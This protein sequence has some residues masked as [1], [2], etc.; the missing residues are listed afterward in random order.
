MLGMAL[1][2]PACSSDSNTAPTN[3][4]G[5][6]TPAPVETA[7]PEPPTNVSIT[8]IIFLN[9]AGNFDPPNPDNEV[10]KE[11]EKRTNTKL[12]INWV[13]DNDYGAKLA[14]IL[15]G[16]DLSDLVF[17]NDIFSSQFQTMAAQGAFW[18]LSDLIN[19]ND[20]PHLTAFPEESW[21]NSKL[22]DGKNYV[23]PKV[24]P[25][26]GNGH[27]IIR[28]DWLDNLKLEVPATLDELY[29]AAKAFTE[30][31][32]DGNKQKDT[33]GFGGES[34]QYI[35][36]AFT[37][38]QGDW[39]LRDGKLINV[40]LLPEM[41]EA[42]LYLNKAY[43]EGLIPV[44]FSVMGKTKANQLGQ[45]GQA[46]IFW[47]VAYWNWALLEPLLKMNPQ[48]SFIA[49]PT[50][51]GYTPQ[52]S[53]F[54]GG[55]AIPRTVPE[56]K[57]KKLLK[58]MDYGA[59]EEGVEL[60]WYG[61]AGRDFTVENGVKIIN[62]SGRKAG[63]GY[64]TYGQIFNMFDKY[65]RAYRSGIPGDLYEQNKKVIDAIEGKSTPNHSYGLYSEA[66]LKMGAEIKKKFT[67]LKT[68]VILGNEKIEAWDALVSSLQ[69]NKDLQLITD[70]LNAAYRQKQR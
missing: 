18:P 21:N 7:K 64:E 35:E 49:V 62:E 32:P 56:A 29:A 50:L 26:D 51:E 54:V 27:V 61:F 60:S 44:D 17:I 46:G 2:L 52:G 9:P 63:A 70:E 37:G 3:K 13:P 53:G 23:I 42:L 1:L 67:D 39:A 34:Y 20:H 8:S 68:K 41:R 57:V 10:Q 30:N 28:K 48:A 38:T 11:I 43:R 16:G 24:R 19:K 31:D 58:F 12:T 47:D 22:R 14:V 45:S 65:Q 4:P 40:N 5:E 15:A 66:N 36:S 6:N 69:A 59:S 25:L 33:I 55:F